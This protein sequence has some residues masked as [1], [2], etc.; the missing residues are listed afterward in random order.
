MLT[1]PNQLYG[2]FPVRVPAYGWH[3]WGIYVG[4]VVLGCLV[5]G[6]LFAR[7]A[8]ED[9]LKLVAMLYL[10]CG[11]GAFHPHAPWPLLHRLPLFASQHVPSR[12]LYP[13]LLLL[14]LVFV[15]WAAR[16]VDGL[17]ARRP[18]WDLVLLIAVALIGVDLVRVSAPT[19]GQA[20]WME[21]PPD[22]K[23][24]PTFEHHTASP[25]HYVRQDWAPPM[26]LAMRANAGVIKCYGID[27]N[28]TGI[29]AVAKDDP[30][31]RGPAYV[32]GGAGRAEVLDW[33]PN[34]ARVRVTGATPGALVVYNMNWD[35]SWRADSAPALEAHHAVAARARGGDQEIV[36]RYFPRT[37]VA[38][39]PLF[40]LTLG[41]CVLVPRW[42]R[43]RKRISD[44]GKT[45][46]NVC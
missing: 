8:R 40:L 4:P 42:W 18:W 9:A 35:P 30:H 20:F 27:P 45:P 31:Y 5:V 21:A 33:S 11:F 41:L 13:M 19:I 15:A 24:A 22:L 28:F 26:L 14:G 38:S 29:G 44:R 43:I 32:E 1:D 7:G 46:E 37:L 6:A 39:I 3:E 2:R 17:V 10:L 12:F 25:V 34:H 16:W 36:F 23:A